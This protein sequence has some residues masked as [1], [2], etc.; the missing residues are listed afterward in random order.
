MV[1]VVYGLLLLLVMYIISSS[2]LVGAVVHVESVT[3]V[4]CALTR[5]YELPCHA[6]NT[7]SYCSSLVGAVALLESVTVVPC[8]LTRHY[9]FP[10][11]AVNTH[12]TTTHTLACSCVHS[13]LVINTQSLSSG[14]SF[15]MRICL[16]N[17]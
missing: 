15:V 4:P 17:F 3:V 10:C 16:H 8:A 11:H 9:A 7:H 5:H 13:T 6:V 1:C 12:S 2:S 14:V